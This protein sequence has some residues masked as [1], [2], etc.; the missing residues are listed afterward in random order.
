MYC[1]KLL[2]LMVGLTIT[3]AATTSFSDDRDYSVVYDR[4]KDST[5]L[6][7]K[8]DKGDVLF[9]HTMHQQVMKDE[10]CLPCH[11]TTTPTQESPLTRL[12]KRKAHFFCKGCHSNK[13]K[14]P[15]EC[16]ECHKKTK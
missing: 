10:S 12:D 16:H 3:L 9:N 8:S 6:V 7:F 5:I 11:K 15:T 14:G 2:M 1:K 13:G 4:K